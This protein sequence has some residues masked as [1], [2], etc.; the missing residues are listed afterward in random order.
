MRSGLVLVALCAIVPLA[1]QPGPEDD[2]RAEVAQMAAAW[3]AGN[4]AGHVR[5]YADSAAMMGTNGPFTGRERIRASLERAFWKDG[6]PL[7]Q[8]QFERVTVRLA[9]SGRVAVVT[10]RFLLTGGGKPDAPGWFTT[11]WEFQQEGWRIIMD[12]S[13]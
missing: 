4:L 7:Q 1:P 3:N 11:V 10:G 2:L 12:H 13:S 9:A 5:P 8:L 6:R